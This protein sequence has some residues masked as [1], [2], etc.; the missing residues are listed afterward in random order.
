[1]QT[2]TA[3]TTHAMVT[4]PSDNTTSSSVKSNDT[5]DT[6][7]CNLETGELSYTAVLGNKVEIFFTIGHLLKT[8][9]DGILQILVQLF[10]IIHFYPSFN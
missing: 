3:G 9:T 5:I 6:S 1:M 10:A 8:S 7:I 2:D 4:S